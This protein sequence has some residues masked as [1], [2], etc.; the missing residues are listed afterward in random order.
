DLA[1]GS[2]SLNVFSVLLGNGTGGYL[3]PI[4]TT[5]G[6]EAVV[7]AAGDVNADG[8]PDL[9][10]QVD[11]DGTRLLL[12]DGTGHFS[13]GTDVATGQTARALRLS[14]LNRDGR[15]D[16]VVGHPQRGTVAV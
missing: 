11:P 2:F 15:L 3:A 10:V 13:A 14:D 5:T 1:V 6:G 12:G 16:L 7:R 8:N 9:I 4:V